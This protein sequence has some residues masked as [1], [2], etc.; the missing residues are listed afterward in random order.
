MV[1]LGSESRNIVSR[2]EPLPSGQLCLPWALYLPPQPQSFQVPKPCT[3]MKLQRLSLNNRISKCG[4]SELSTQRKFKYLWIHCFCKVSINLQM[5][6][7]CHF[8]HSLSLVTDLTGSLSK[9]TASSSTLTRT[10]KK[11]SLPC[12]TTSYILIAYGNVSSLN[13][14][15]WIQFWKCF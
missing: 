15:Q 4:Q 8:S 14:I 7:Y 6:I 11:S 13:L 5:L 3:C 2:T 10:V 12:W 1:D 9:I